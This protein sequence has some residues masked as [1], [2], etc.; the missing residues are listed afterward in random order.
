MK[1][2]TKVV[3]RLV[4][5]GL[6]F[7]V[8]FFVLAIPLFLSY[9]PM[10][11]DSSGDQSASRNADATASAQAM[12]AT[13][14]IEDSDGTPDSLD[15]QSALPSSPPAIPQACD[16]KEDFGPIHIN[17]VVVLGQHRPVK[18]DEGWDEAMDEYVRMEAMVTEL[19]GVDVQGCP[20][21]RV[22]VDEGVYR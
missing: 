14:A 16:G 11:I 12:A 1:S 3:F 22:D 6:I 8:I 19:A 7:C 5:G 13:A 21:V 20:V 18:N 4:I 10:D 2:K 15:G 17:N 9:I